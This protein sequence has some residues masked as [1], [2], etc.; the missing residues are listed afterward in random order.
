MDAIKPR[1]AKAAIKERFP[2]L[3][4]ELVTRLSEI[5]LSDQYQIEG[6]SSFNNDYQLDLI[7]F[8]I[9]IFELYGKPEYEEMIA[10]FMDAAKEEQYAFDERLRDRV[11]RVLQKARGGSKSNE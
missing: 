11:Y 3:L 10:D 9:L 6:K 5:L 7:I 2:A 8:D 1:R 4:A